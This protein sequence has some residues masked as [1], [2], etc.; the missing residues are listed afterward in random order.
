MTLFSESEDQKLFEDLWNL[1]AE[2]SMLRIMI[3]VPA[4]VEISFAKKYPVLYSFYLRV[5]TPERI[6]KEK[7]KQP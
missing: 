1:I 7:E 3:P 4:E 5:A 2:R 6:K